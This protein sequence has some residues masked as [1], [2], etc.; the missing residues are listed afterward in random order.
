MG[1]KMELYLK[2]TKQ[3]IRMFKEVE[4]EQ[5]SRTRNY[6]A[7]MLARMAGTADAELPKLVPLEIKTSPSI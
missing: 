4:I 1:E 7:D 3:L 5:I 2:K 6:R